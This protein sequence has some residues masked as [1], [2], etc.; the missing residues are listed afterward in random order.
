MPTLPANGR[1]L[2]GDFFDLHLTRRSGLNGSERLG[3]ADLQAWQ[4]VTG[5]RHE[6][7]EVRAIFRLDN[8]FMAF[9]AREAAKR[10]GA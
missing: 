1:K 10:Q 5:L 4:I 3:F 9:Q 7:W 2:W 8:E 6:P